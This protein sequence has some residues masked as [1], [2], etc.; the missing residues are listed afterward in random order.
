MP[1]FSELL[2]EVGNSFPYSLSA[3]SSL[4]QTPSRESA[5]FPRTRWFSAYTCV[6]EGTDLAEPAP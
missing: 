3:H 6:R 1:H 4:V 5:N 2:P